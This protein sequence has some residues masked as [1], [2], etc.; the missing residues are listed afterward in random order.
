MGAEAYLRALGLGAL[1]SREITTGG[2][3]VTVHARE[4]SGAEAEAIFSVLRDET[5]KIPPE[6]HAEMRNRVVSA[7]IC[8][9]HGLPQLA[10]DEVSALPYSLYAPLAV[11]ALEVN[12][13]SEP[14][15]T[16]EKKG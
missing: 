12:G 14:S 9:A 2:K 13:L 16:E 1:H 6:R 4:I 5:G 11:F 15:E 10:V 7:S 3:V 8:D